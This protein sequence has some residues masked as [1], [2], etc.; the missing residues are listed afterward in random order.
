MLV[1]LY[2]CCVSNSISKYFT[3]YSDVN[4]EV[5][6]SIVK[7]VFY[8]EMKKTIIYQKSLPVSFV[9]DLP[10]IVW[11]DSTN[12]SCPSEPQICALKQESSKIHK[13]VV[14]ET[15]T[16]HPYL[17]NTP[18]RN[19]RGL[20]DAV[21]IIDKYLFGLATTAD[22]DALHA[23]EGAIVERLKQLQNGMVDE[24]KY[25]VDL[26]G[27]ISAWSSKLS[28]TF[29]H[30]LDQVSKH[31]ISTAE[32]IYKEEGVL[33]QVALDIMKNQ[34]LM[35]TTNKINLAA[36]S[37]RNNRIPRT[38]LK[39]IS[40]NKRL[41]TLEKKLLAEGYEYAVS[42]Q[43]L[44]KMD[45]SDCFFTERKLHVTV[46]VPLRLV[47]TSYKLFEVLAV[48]WQFGNQQCRVMDV[49]P[50]VAKVGSTVMPIS[51]HVARY[52]MPQVQNACY[53]PE[54]EKDSSSFSDCAKA[55]FHL[56]NENIKKVSEMFFVIIR[57]HCI[58]NFSLE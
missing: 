57:C 1:N 44:M 2:K 29:Q 49:T 28:N 39:D 52:C 8:Q 36:E 17:R 14:L 47:N 16:D 43:R 15:L 42:V 38:I 22:V 5:Y 48:P 54:N 35:Y 26:S 12:E 32:T 33:G 46:H 34:Y 56:F 58:K 3:I 4:C 23:A 19:T 27:N 7:G 50:F 53:I 55:I 30:R 51:G 25:L 37:C 13:E 20:I 40:L 21:G 45:I 41:K 10:Q 6:T 18:T 24:H 9:V 11:K 31:L